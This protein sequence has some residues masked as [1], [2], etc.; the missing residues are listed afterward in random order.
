MNNQKKY[1]IGNYNIEGVDSS[2]I[3]EV[4]EFLATQA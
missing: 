4:K 1:F 3:Q 2:S